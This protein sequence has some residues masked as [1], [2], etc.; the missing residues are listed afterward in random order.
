MWRRYLSYKSDVFRGV[1]GILSQGYR[2]IKYSYI[3]KLYHEF[4]LEAWA[5][6]KTLSGDFIIKNVSSSISH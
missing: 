4:K 2:S 6:A 1:W 5:T 3:N